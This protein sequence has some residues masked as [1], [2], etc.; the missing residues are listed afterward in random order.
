MRNF[1]RDLWPTWKQ[2]Q[3]WSMPSKL[4]FIG[5]YAGIVSLFLTVATLAFTSLIKTTIDEA[6]IP[7]KWDRDKA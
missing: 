7:G 3:K 1:F 6:L 4:M 5:A 2:F